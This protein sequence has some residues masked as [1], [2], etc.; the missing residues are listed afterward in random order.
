MKILNWS[1]IPSANVIGQSIW[2]ELYQESSNVHLN[3]EQVEELFCQKSTSKP[4]I[5]EKKKLNK[6]ASEVNL[7]DPKR[8]LNINIFLK[9]FKGGEKQLVELIQN[10]Q[11]TKIGSERLRTLI[12][13]LPA[14]NEL[15]SVKEYNGDK[16]RLG[17]AEKFYL[18]L[19]EVKAYKTR[20][21]GMIQIEEFQPSVDV[22]KPQIKHYLETCETILNNKSLKDFFKII[23]VTGNFLNSGS[24]A[25]NAFGFRLNTLGKLMETR[26][27]KPRMTLLHYL[28]DVAEKEDQEMLNFTN[29]LQFLSEC[30]K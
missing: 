11:S 1:K 3:F 18:L 8:S 9:Q 25:G 19:S 28:V 27:N 16:T 6:N 24:Y 26:A 29:D 12:K 23:L 2:N 20:I 30:S 21:Q 13:I 4:L 14:C 22:L 17:I 15:I 10:C 5:N 7:L